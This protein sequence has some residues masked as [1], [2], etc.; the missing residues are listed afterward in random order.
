MYGDYDRFLGSLN[1]RHTDA[2]AHGDGDGVG[3]SEMALMSSEQK[4]SLLPPSQDETHSIIG[5][6]TEITASN[7]DNDLHWIRVTSARFAGQMP[8]IRH[9]RHGGPYYFGC[10]FFLFSSFLF[11]GLLLWISAQYKCHRHGVL[12]PPEISQVEVE[13]P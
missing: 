11:T 2:M 1:V 10:S 3:D 5:D 8:D 4:P 7:S 12:P 6:I 13:L 9:W